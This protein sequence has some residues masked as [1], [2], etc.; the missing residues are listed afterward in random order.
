M[1]A[2]SHDALRR[3]ARPENHARNPSRP[4]LRAGRARTQNFGRFGQCKIDNRRE[5]GVEAE[6]LHRAG[7]QLAV[8]SRQG[9]GSA[10]LFGRGTGDTRCCCHGLRRGNRRERIAQTIYRSAFDIDAAN[11][12]GAAE[13]GGFFKQRARLLRVFDIAP[14]EDDARRA[15]Q[16]EPGALQAGQL[17]AAEPHHQQASCRLPHTSSS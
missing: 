16:S 3:D 1:L 12:P 14:E 2:A 7:N 5:R 11:G 10:C 17:R 9:A 13:S 6:R 15:H 4:R 8:L